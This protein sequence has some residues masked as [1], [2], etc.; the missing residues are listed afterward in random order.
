VRPRWPATRSAFEL[1]EKGRVLTGR[2][3]LRELRRDGGSDLR[4]D[5]LASRRR[6]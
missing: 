4:R 3:L 5:D 6:A 2:N 1:V